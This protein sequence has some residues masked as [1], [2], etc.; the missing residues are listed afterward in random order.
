MKLTKKLRQQHVLRDRKWEKEI[1]ARTGD[2]TMAAVFKV[3]HDDFGWGA[4]RIRRLSAG[5]IQ[6]MNCMA[7][8]YVTPFQ[9]FDMLKEE[10]GYDWVKEG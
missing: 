5:I 1:T 7:E 8:G 10:T 4:T 2:I 3:L 9:I 6:Q